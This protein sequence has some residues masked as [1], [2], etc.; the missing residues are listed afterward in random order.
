MSSH[1]LCPKDD[2]TAELLIKEAKVRLN[3]LDNE[4]AIK[5]LVQASNIGSSVEN[6]ILN[7]VNASMCDPDMALWLA[8]ALTDENSGNFSSAEYNYWLGSNRY[9]RHPRC[10]HSYGKVLLKQE[11]YEDAESWLLNAMALS[12][13]ASQIRPDLDTCWMQQGVPHSSIKNATIRIGVPQLVD[14]ET[15]KTVSTMLI[16]SHLSTAFFVGVQRASKDPFGVVEYIVST[17]EFQ[18][19]NMG[20]ISVLKELGNGWIDRPNAT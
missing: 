14:L 12:I 10:V 4:T 20:L 17:P 6:I 11:K 9:P 2:L 18:A 3:F 15:I 16:G 19:E 13:P 8:Q 5:L 1:I 7:T